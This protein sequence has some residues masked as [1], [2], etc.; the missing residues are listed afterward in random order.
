MIGEIWKVAKTFV[1]L[2]DSL[3]RYHNEIKDIRE[4]LRDL[5]IIVHV[6][7]QDIKNFKEHTAQEHEKL[8]L[9]VENRLLKH[10]RM[11]PPE[12]KKPVRK[13]GKK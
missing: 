8:L 12:R 11:L 2:A 4:E 7:A 10:E 3:E 13:K 1:T 9:E 6:L 5:T